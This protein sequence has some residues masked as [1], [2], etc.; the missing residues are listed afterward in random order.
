MNHLYN[1]IEFAYAAGLEAPNASEWLEY[2]FA[3]CMALILIAVLGGLAV[4][5]PRLMKSNQDWMAEHQ[6][7]LLDQQEKYEK[8]SKSLRD[9][10]TLRIDAIIER[11]REYS[12]E[13]ITHLTKEFLG[14]VKR[15][16]EVIESFN[17]EK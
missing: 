11:E 2:G 8:I 9:E 6:K 14:E 15:L 13:I 5:L 16:Q 3:G 1:T 4:W 17:R 7:V 12:R 10:T